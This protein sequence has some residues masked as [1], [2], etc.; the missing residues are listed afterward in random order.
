[1]PSYLLDTNVVL[2]LIDRQDP[3]HIV[4]RA[5][6][7]ILIRQQAE[8]CLAPQILVEFWVVAARPA[9][10]NGLGWSPEETDMQ[11][12]HLCGFFPLRPEYPGIFDH[13]RRRIARQA[14]VRGKRAHDARIAAFMSFHG[15]GAVL[16]LNP[17][18]F[19]GLGVKVVEPDKLANSLP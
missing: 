6:I 17:N 12:G 18:D 2:R 3:K 15:I 5:A 14:A 16:A 11:I 1:M 4:C 10:N 19:H 8:I 13:W 9:E 7:D